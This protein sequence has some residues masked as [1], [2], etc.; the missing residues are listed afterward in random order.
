MKTEKKIKTVSIKMS[1]Y[2]STQICISILQNKESSIKAKKE[3]IEELL[4]YATELD[5]I[6]NLTNNK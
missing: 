1:F 2:Y 3:A 5:R 4:R 6:D